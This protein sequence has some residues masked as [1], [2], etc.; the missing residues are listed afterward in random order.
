SPADAIDAIKPRFA[1]LL[2][3]PDWL[4]QRY[5]VAAPESEMGG[6][7]GQWLIYRALDGSLSLF[8]LVIPSRSETPIHDHLAW[9]LVGLY[10]GNQGKRSTRSRGRR[11]RSAG[12]GHSSPGTSIRGSHR[13]RTS[14]GS[15]RPPAR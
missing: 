9:G 14:T 2:A 11:S 15:G 13:S 12:A 4:P 1:A 3:D 10:K 7:I 6:G 8:S 5:S